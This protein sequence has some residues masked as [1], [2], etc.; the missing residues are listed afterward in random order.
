MKDKIVLLYWTKLGIFG[1]GKTTR[2]LL[3]YYFDEI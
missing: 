2:I 1:Y 3:Y